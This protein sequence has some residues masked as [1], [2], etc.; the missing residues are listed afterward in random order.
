MIKDPNITLAD[1]I[2]QPFSEE[3][4]KRFSHA[5]VFRPGEGGT[6]DHV[7]FRLNIHLDEND[8]ITR[9]NYG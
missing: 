1:L 8:I 6:M 9:F 5:R 7:P 4:Q 2:G 3:L